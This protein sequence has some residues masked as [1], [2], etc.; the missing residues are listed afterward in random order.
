MLDHFLKLVAFDV[1]GLPD[2]QRRVLSRLRTDALVSLGDL[3]GM[4]TGDQSGQWPVNVDEMLTE[5]DIEGA[6]DELER[7]G[8][9]CRLEGRLVGDLVGSVPQG[10]GMS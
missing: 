8:L 5:Q 6:L 2:L 10:R 3:L 7:S 4:V 9:A 1:P